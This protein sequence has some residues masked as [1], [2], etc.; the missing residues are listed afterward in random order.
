MGDSTG[1]ALMVAE[2]QSLEICSVVSRLI[3]LS[4]E[5]DSPSGDIT[6]RSIGG[7]H[8][9]GE[10]RIVAKERLVVCGG[11]VLEAI[12]ARA[13][14]PMLI[15]QCILD[16]EV[17]T[18]KD[19]VFELSGELGE[20]LR[21]ERVLLN[22]LQHLSGV[23][24]H[25]RNVVEQAPPGI[26]LLDTRKTL[27][28]F[29]SLEKY[30]VRVGGGK[31]HRMSLSDRVLIKDNHIDASQ[32]SPAELI[33]ESRSAVSQQI[34]IEVEV[35]TRAEL[36][37]AIPGRPDVIMLDNMSIDELRECVAEIRKVNPNIEIEIS[38]GIS[39]ETLPRYRE[40]IGCSL[41]MGSLTYGARHVDLSMNIVPQRYTEN[42]H[43]EANS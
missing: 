14:S 42:S 30:A 16:G 38:G 28:G 26:T 6:V 32:K 43:Q 41:S 15:S 17:A 9:R 13:H 8:V 23:A 35:R 40:F 39:A 2:R 18:P 12:S 11:P 21:I 24:T 4:L 34:R 31:N 5:E 7:L 36:A 19:V 29:R 3:D 22:F 33:R 1:W 20:L 37:E 27:P 25:V 10:G